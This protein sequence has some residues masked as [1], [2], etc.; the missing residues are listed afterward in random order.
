MPTIVMT[1]T[2]D[3]LDASMKKKAYA[4][5]E[6]LGA[7]DSAPGLHVEPIHNCVDLR[8]RTGRVDD[9]FRAVMFKLTGTGEP[10]YVLHGIWKHDEAIARAKRARLALNSVNG[11]PEIQEVLDHVV[12]EAAETLASQPVRPPPPVSPPSETPSALAPPTPIEDPLPE[13]GA[14][15]EDSAVLPSSITVTTL[16]DE[17]G[18]DPDLS[19]RAVAATTPEAFTATLNSA[20]ATWQGLALIDLS[21]GRSVQEIRESYG[22]AP[23]EVSVENEDDQIRQAIREKPAAQTAFA[24]IEDND[25][26]RRVIEEGDFGAWRLYL[27]P[28]QRRFVTAQYNGPARVSGGA[29]TGKT[30]V[31]MHRA[32]RLAKADPDARLLVTTFTRNLAE[33]LRTD[34]KRLDETIPVPED[35]DDP[36]IRVSGIDALVLAVLYRFGDLSA[37][38]GMVLGA[39]QP[40]LPNQADD[41]AWDAAISAHAGDLPATLRARAFFQSEYGLVVLPHRITTAA[42][43]FRIPRPGR[44]VALD[45]AKRAIVWKVIEAYRTSARLAGKASYLERAAVATAA[46]EAETAETGKALFDHVLVDETQDLTPVHLQFLR[47]LV[48]PGPNDLFIA[49]DSHQRI[50]GDK[51][52]LSHYGINIRGRSRRLTLNYRTTAANLDFAIKVLSGGDYTDLEG[53]AE[54]HQYRSLNPGVPPLAIHASGLGDAFEQAAD[55]VG[56]WVRDLGDHGSPETIG[57]LVRNSSRRSDVVSALQERG[58]TVRSVDR[59][60]VKSGLPVVMTMHRAKGLEFTHVLL[61]DVGARSIPRSLKDY[62]SSPADHAD[63][64]LR[65]RSLLYVA[66][67]RA[68]DVL[69]V[70]WSG[71]VSQFLEG[72]VPA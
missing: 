37:A 48:I 21:E 32:R 65:E 47:A 24:W 22:L 13:P 20:S 11:V 15:A 17:L 1:Q 27:H 40:E 62:E 12:A 31:V 23:V 52:T 29:G 44:G 39:S 16:Q 10:A 26:L 72:V 9:N 2:K 25:E 67:T 63:A 36:G 7:D 41:D 4:F 38:T 6:K 45:R 43:Y 69:A 56:Q 66:A 19:R 49:E 54:K 46:L 5:L 34:L 42:A 58:V 70:I 14:P 51:V 35:F 8:V 64:L 18:L 53:D 33:S 50:Y 68:R 3:G 61:F 59:E 60:S 71:Q 30:V 55:L 28:E 57:I